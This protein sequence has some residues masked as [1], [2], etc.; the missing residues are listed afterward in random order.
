MTTMQHKFPGREVISM[1]KNKQTNKQ[2]ASTNTTKTNNRTEF[3]DEMN[4]AKDTQ[5]KN[6][7]KQ[8]KK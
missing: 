7:N 5:A 4:N 2:T 6:N 8:Y 3:A 1:D